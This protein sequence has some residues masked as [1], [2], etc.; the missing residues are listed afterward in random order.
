MFD[1]N[2]HW[3]L[4]FIY[5]LEVLSILDPLP[6]YYKIVYVYIYEVM[7]AFHC[8]YTPAIMFSFHAPLLLAGLTSSLIF[9]EREILF[10]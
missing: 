9:S 5:I 1:F 8:G 10:G 7:T 6:L 2:M 4:V 3:R